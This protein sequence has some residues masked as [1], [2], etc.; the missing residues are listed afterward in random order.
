VAGRF[1]GHRD[2]WV[3]SVA[4]SPD[5]QHIVSSSR[6]QTIRVWN[7]VTGETAVGPFIGHSDWVLS[8]E[9]SQ[10]GQHIISGSLDRTTRVWDAM[11]GETVAGPFTGHTDRVTSVAFSPDG[12]R[13]VSGSNDRTIRVSN[14]AI[15]KTE[16]TNDVGF[17]DHFV[18]NDE[19]WICGS[20]GELLMWTPSEHRGCL[21]PPSTIW[22]SGKCGTILNLSNFVLDAVGLL[23]SI[24]RY[25]YYNNI[26]VNF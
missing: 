17:T 19:G 3:N 9:F 10:D 1:R 20:K 13:I 23:A 6:D 15:G 26:V 11:T 7:A 22:I 24:L 5:G 12:K 4:F 16:T 25:Q 2:D 8:V 18:I 14:V 21:Q